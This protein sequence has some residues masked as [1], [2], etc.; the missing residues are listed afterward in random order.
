MVQEE[1]KYGQKVLELTKE[2]CDLKLEVKDHEK[3][4]EVLNR[5]IAEVE[6]D[7]LKLENQN[8]LDNN[9]KQRSESEAKIAHLERLLSQSSLQSTGSEAS[10]P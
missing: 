10:I 4:A 5:K 3:E 1:K 8:L 2:I 7:K 9:V 6:R